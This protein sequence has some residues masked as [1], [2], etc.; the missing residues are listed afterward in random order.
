MGGTSSKDPDVVGTRFQSHGE[1]HLT[2]EQRKLQRGYIWCK[3]P[4]TNG[5]VLSAQPLHLQDEVARRTLC[6]YT[7]MRLRMAEAVEA[8]KQRGRER[9]WGFYYQCMEARVRRSRES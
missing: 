9:F 6:E 7:I 4:Q 2:D 3:D 1:V 8:E 5:R